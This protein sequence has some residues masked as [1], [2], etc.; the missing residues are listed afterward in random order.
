MFLQGCEMCA[1]G[2]VCIAKIAL[3]M[4]FTLPGA[5]R[6]QKNNLMFGSA[7]EPKRT[8]DVHQ[9]CVEA[10][11]VDGARAVATCVRQIMLDAQRPL[12]ST[13]SHGDRFQIL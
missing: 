1:E 7:W 3:A 10:Q 13:T 8:I 9:R 2:M 11:G 6:C 12:D 4:T 5:Q